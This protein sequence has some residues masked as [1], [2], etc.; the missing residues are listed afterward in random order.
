MQ[1]FYKSDNDI[2]IWMTENDNIIEKVRFSDVSTF[3]RCYEEKKLE[4]GG[5]GRKT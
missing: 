4:G 2:Q 3:V 5:G 1:H